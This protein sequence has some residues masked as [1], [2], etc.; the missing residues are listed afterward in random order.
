MSESFI[1][2][3]AT[4]I[5]AVA[6][7][8]IAAAMVLMS[9]DSIEPYRVPRSYH[10]Q[11][12]DWADNARHE[13]VLELSRDRLVYHPN[14]TD[15]LWYLGVALDNLGEHEEARQTLLRLKE[16]TGTNAIPMVDEYL[17]KMK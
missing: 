10:T 14:D 8:A 15:A 1:S 7:V 17:Q 12:D 16:I 5:G 6:L 9:M 13:R 4:I 3:T 11:I 2:K